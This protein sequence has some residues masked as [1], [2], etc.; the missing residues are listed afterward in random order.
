[1]HLREIPGRKTIGIRR[2]KFYWLTSSPGRLFGKAAS[3]LSKQ[4]YKNSNVCLRYTTLK[5]TDTL[6]NPGYVWMFAVQ[7][8]LSV[9]TSAVKLFLQNFQGVLVCKGSYLGVTWNWNCCHC[10]RLVGHSSALAMG[11]VIICCYVEWG[12]KVWHG[13]LQTLPAQTGDV[14]SWIS[15]VNG[16]CDKGLSAGCSL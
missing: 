13:V 14:Q 11:T 16:H 6:S 9:Q 5:L 15:E 7:F 2:G 3:V 10:E 12:V 8:L 1:M 4:C